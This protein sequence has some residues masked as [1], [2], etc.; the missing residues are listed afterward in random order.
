MFRE[1]P[2]TT[3]GGTKNSGKIHPVNLVIC[4]RQ[5]NS[6]DLHDALNQSSKYIKKILNLE[7]YLFIKA[8][9]AG[10]RQFYLHCY[11]SLNKLKQ[12]ACSI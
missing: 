7:E 6:T 3:A 5:V 11:V 1:R 12:V 9:T 2:L 10:P 8:T 4:P